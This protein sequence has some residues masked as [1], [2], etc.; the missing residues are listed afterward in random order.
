MEFCLLGPVEARREGRPVGLSG[1]KMRTLLAALLL[2]RGRVVPDSR[3]SWLLWGMCPPVTMSAQIYTYVSRLRKLL[4]PEV[5]IVRRAPGYAI[6]AEGSR[7]DIVEFERLERLG[8]TA[9]QERRYDEAGTLLGKALD[10][11]RGPAL[12]HT[13]EFLVE[14]EEPQWE[15]G[16]AAALENRM[17]AD[18]A[19]G[20]HQQVTAELT[21]LVGEFPLRERMRAQ[22]MTALCRSGRQADAL[23]SF[24]EGRGALADEL[25][26]EPG[27]ELTDA[28]Q[29]VL[30][31]SLAT[32]PARP[33]TGMVVFA[34]GPAPAMLPAEP[35]PFVGRE[36]ELEA[37]R[38]LLAPSEHV[39]RG[40]ITGMAGVGK[41]ALALRAARG[42]AQDFPDGQLYADL[43][44][45]EGRAKDTRA[46]LVRLLRALGHEAAGSAACDLDDLVRLYRARTDGAKL[47]VVL[48]N[49]ADGAQLSAL[50]PAGA[51]AAVL[52][53]G[54]THLSV[55]TGPHTV[56]VEPM[57]EDDSLGLLA[58]AAGADRVAADLAA[59]RRIAEH[60]DGLPLALRIAG[61]R[62]VSRPRWSVGLLAGRLEDPGNRLR[63][64]R[65]GDLDLARS[66]RAWLRRT[67][68]DPD[69]LRRFTALGGRSFCAATA[70]TLLG[71]SHATT[72]DLLEQLAD[73]SLI[74]PA[75]PAGGVLQYRFH[76]LVLLYARSLPVRMA[77]G[78]ALPA[79]S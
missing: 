27:S 44:D 64:L 61:A 4:E 26:V 56:A 24:H 78:A 9:L 2:A 49:V 53:V 31:G 14:H 39:R 1:A 7:I 42:C 13:T 55:A 19:L 47:L 67:G 32:A 62:L 10:L 63:E 77:A 74:E 21:R 73:A 43:S 45:G 18:L 23:R 36:R 33:A 16:R 48:D 65:F 5:T 54:H 68:V 30:D 51:E 46:V 60:C 11:W 17:E 25:G 20:R 28:Y 57:G 50:L 71:L 40:L 35:G 3:L 8:R 37:V 58:A 72:E 38:R 52:V 41:T 76:R 29:A 15:E 34:S 70:A 22:L 12:G 69:V 79:A 75:D 6:E 59:A 66:L